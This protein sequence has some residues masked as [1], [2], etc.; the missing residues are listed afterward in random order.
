[1][2]IRSWDIFCTVID[3]FGDIGVCWRL[4]RQLAQEHGHAVRLWV[5]DLG[6]FARLAPEIDVT[7]PSQRL[8]GVEVHAWDPQGGA[9]F[10]APVPH[11]VV[12]E[13]FACHLPEP[14]LAAMAA[15]P[16]K[17]VWINLEY[18]SAE[19]WVAEHHGM[20]S[21]HP[22]LPLVKYFFFPGFAH[23]TGGL[24]RE[25]MIGAS[26]DAFRDSAAAHATLWHRLGVQPM[27]DSLKVSL[28]AY[29]NPV[30]TA[31]LEQWRDG[32]TR[33]E[34]FVPQG[35]AATQI[36]QWLGASLAPGSTHHRANLVVHGIPFV[37][38]EHYDELLWA[39]DVNFVRGEDSCVRAHW[40]ARPMIWQIY[41]QD[42]NAHHV[43]L[44]AW[45]QR[46]GRAGVSPEASAALTAFSHAWNGYGAAPDWASLQAQLPALNAG[47]D[48][49]QRQ[50]QHLG[51]LAANLVAF[52]E[53]Q[54]K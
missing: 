50:L 27:R 21:P 20:N 32:S 7:R 46:F 4:A 14:F 47:M 41:P 29:T 11:D 23:G 6:S 19:D 35:P 49:W 5:D 37:R 25:S 45:L 34:C 22:R 53:N 44:D 48:R 39:C 16:R 8:G 38:Q 26:R 3:N 40:A 13:A 36:E 9:P 12:I 28:F 43:K 31:L 18:M 1:M 24:L 30:M 2:P 15:A 10:D 54:V 17:P 42:D 51:D 52:S 33:I